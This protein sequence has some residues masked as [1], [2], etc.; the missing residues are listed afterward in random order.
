MYTKRTKPTSSDVARRI[1]EYYI[2]R[3]E[4]LNLEEYYASI[5]DIEYMAYIMAFKKFQT[6]FEMEVK[7]L[8]S[9]NELHKL[10]KFSH[11]V[12]FSTKCAKEL[13]YINYQTWKLQWLN[14]NDLYDK[15]TNIIIEPL[16]RDELLNLLEIYELNTVSDINIAIAKT[17]RSCT[18]SLIMR[19]LYIM[20]MKRMKK[21]DILGR[22]ATS[23]EEPI[24]VLDRQND[25]RIDLEASDG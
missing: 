1:E 23:E 20:Y 25:W 11:M 4:K 19:E 15:I 2:V 14:I 22:P 17:Q 24:H 3:L 7:R 21:I 13:N 9:K 18:M 10:Q 12:G 6:F 16:K 5:C 8:T